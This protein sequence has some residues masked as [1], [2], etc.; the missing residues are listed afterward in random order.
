MGAGMETDSLPKSLE[1]SSQ[2]PKQPSSLHQLQA[3]PL[4]CSSQSRAPHSAHEQLVHTHTHTHTHT[5]SGD[6]LG[7]KNLAVCMAD[8]SV[9][10]VLTVSQEPH[11]RRGCASVPALILS[12]LD[13]GDSLSSRE[14]AILGL[15]VALGYIKTIAVTCIASWLCL[16]LVRPVT[17]CH[18]FRHSHTHARGSRGMGR[19]ACAGGLCVYVRACAPVPFCQ[20]AGRRHMLPAYT[21][22]R[23][24]SV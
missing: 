9:E 1:H 13:G 8:G 12:L 3:I 22:G 20:L 17:I 6:R 24:N 19:E 5:L 11:C 2:S 15:S 23:G 4:K 14:A 16:T 10:P 7:L 21:T 18:Q